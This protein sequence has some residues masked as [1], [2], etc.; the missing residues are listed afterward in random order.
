[1]QDKDKVNG[2]RALYI[3]FPTMVIT[4]IIH[5]LIIIC[6]ILINIYS[7]RMAEETNESSDCINNI[8]S[9]LSHTSKLSDTVTTFVYTPEIQIGR[10]TYKLNEE[11]LGIYVSEITFEARDPKVISEN[12]KKHTIDTES[13]EYI[14]DSLNKL[15]YVINAQAHA[16][17][18]IASKINIPS[19]LLNAIPEYTLTDEELALTKN[20]VKL[21]AR[22]IIFDKEYS[23]AK[24][25]IANDINLAQ[26][27][28]VS[29]YNLSKDSLSFHLTNL[30]ICLWIMIIT[31]IVI[32]IVFFIVIIKLLV[33]P[34]I[35]FSKKINDNERLDCE[36]GMYEANIL[37]YSYNRLLDRHNQF[38]DELREVAECDSLT[39][40]PNRYSY[41]EFLKKEIP[42]G[43]KACVFML[44][45]NNLKYENDTHGHDKGDEL[46]K[47]ASLC[48][49]EAF[50]ESS[51]CFR[52]GGDEF[53]VI[54][55]NVE[56]DEISNIKKHFI[57]TE[58]KYNVSVAIGYSYSDNVKEIGYEKLVIEADSMMYK[59]K[60][61]VKNIG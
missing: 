44:D 60:E 51:Y 46:I 8:S 29:A 27:S 12:L 7:I 45:I 33:L 32:T 49:K 53:V 30:R 18:L 17:R 3:F 52:T 36:K 19:E 47:N 16:I 37:A 2:I 43:Q 54:L 15:E 1:M 42:D 41:N 38:E 55:N 4:G 5:V 35:S 23:F 59:N 21:K 48:I 13:M 22:E 25:D 34:I 50:G 6:T 26:A 56:R 40:L 28:V 20:E 58:K 31:I 14:N 10:D 11:P 61:K 39:G 24:R 57:E 9:I